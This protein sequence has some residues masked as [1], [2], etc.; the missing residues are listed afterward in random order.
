MATTIFPQN[1]DSGDEV[2]FSQQLNQT[3]V[4]RNHVRTGGEATAVSGL[5]INISE[6]VAL[7]S[8]T[9]IKVDGPIAL[10]MTAN[11]TNFVYLELT[12]SGGLVQTPP[13]DGDNFLVTTSFENGVDK[14]LL[15]VVETGSSSVTT[16]HDARWLAPGQQMTKMRGLGSLLFNEQTNYVG[17]PQLK[18]PLPRFIETTTTQNVVDGAIKVFSGNGGIRVRLRLSST[19]GSASVMYTVHD[20]GNLV[21]ADRIA[22]NQTTFE[23]F[24]TASATEAIIHFSLT[25][26]T[27]DNPGIVVPEIR[28]ATSSTNN[29][30]IQSG[31][32]IRVASQLVGV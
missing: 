20:G 18:V 14:V 16:I 15:A 8:G 13:N 26:G 1:G 31:S 22:A 6:V 5:G 30:S 27:P 29:T 9:Y 32:Y 21:D 11:A 2:A 7:I 24:T 17:D 23:L 4:A 12:R 28:Q 19:P 10:T 3:S 25:T